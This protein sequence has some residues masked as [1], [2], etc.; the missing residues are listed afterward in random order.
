[1][2]KKLLCLAG[3][4][5]IGIFVGYKIKENEVNKLEE[6]KEDILDDINN[7]ENIR[8]IT[9]I[10]CDTAR[11]NATRDYVALVASAHMEQSEAEV[12]SAVAY[13]NEYMEAVVEEVK[14]FDSVPTDSEGRDLSDILA[15]IAGLM[16]D[17]RQDRENDEET[18]DDEYEEVSEEEEYDEEE[19]EEVPTIESV[20]AIRPEYDEDDTDDD[21]YNDDAATVESVLDLHSETSEEDESD[22][23]EDID[24]YDEF[25]NDPEYDPTIYGEHL[26]GKAY[27]ENFC[28]REPEIAKKMDP[29][30][31]RLGTYQFKRIKVVD[32]NGDIVE[33]SVPPSRDEVPDLIEPYAEELYGKEEVEKMRA[34]VKEL[35]DRI[36][37]MFEQRAKEKEE[38]AAR[39]ALNPDPEPEPESAP[40]VSEVLRR[41]EE[42]KANGTYITPQEYD[43][44][45]DAAEPNGEI[46]R[47]QDD[48]EYALKV[49]RELRKKKEAEAAKSSA[50]DEEEKDN[51]IKTLL[52]EKMKQD[53][54]A[55]DEV[56]KEEEDTQPELINTQPKELPPPPSGKIDKKYVEKE[57]Y[58]C[59]CGKIKGIK[60]LNRYCKVC[61]TKVKQL[62]MVLDT[63][64][65]KEPINE[66][67][68]VNI[69]PE[70]P[71]NALNSPQNIIAGNYERLGKPLVDAFGEEY[72]Q[73]LRLMIAKMSFDHFDPDA[74]EDY[75][76]KLIA[77][78]KFHTDS[79]KLD[80]VLDT[81]FKEFG[82]TPF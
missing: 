53:A 73:R 18:Q 15:S 37:A 11:L 16:E 59:A 6:K 52:A 14:E 41:I 7:E 65:L 66:D 13:I 24:D 2:F 3:V 63:S 8:I 81:F 43:E 30:Y 33:K 57:F 62:E 29:M 12:D 25:E 5:G 50:T 56:D 40:T 22:T 1:M 36:F 47:I 28:R 55:D 58:G 21:E 61:K 72:E 80:T 9:N 64:I 77:C 17:I 42:E 39:K 45:F 74:Y 46:T 44:M 67:I 75:E 38:E 32:E 76:T 51:D 68:K 79:K 19:V 82:L 20:L 4:A 49:V 34:H 71:L 70:P 54:E 78:A 35:D 48:K 27:W 69:N 60:N 10:H 26:E 31:W 23:D